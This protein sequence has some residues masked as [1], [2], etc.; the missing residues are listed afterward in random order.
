MPIY[1]R[2]KA[3][4]LNNLGE[5][6]EENGFLGILVEAHNRKELFNLSYP[7]AERVGFEPTVPCGITSFQD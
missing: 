5:L 2:F 6:H 1:L 3:G 4:M 7:M